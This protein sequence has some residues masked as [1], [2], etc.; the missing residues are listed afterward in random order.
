M[1]RHCLR[2]LA[3]LV[4]TG[5]CLSP[6]FAQSFTANC[7]LPFAHPSPK[8]NF[9]RSCPNA[10]I[11][12]DSTGTTDDAAARAVEYERK[13][14]LCAL[15]LGPVVDLDFA[16]LYRLQ[17]QAD[18]K[19]ADGNFKIGHGMPSMPD[20]SV[21]KNMP[22]ADG[23]SIDEGQPVRLV[24]YVADVKKSGSDEGVNCHNT[25]ELKTD[26]HINLSPAKDDP[27]Q[28]VVV[29]ITPHH[30]P[31][32]WNHATTRNTLYMRGNVRV[33]NVVRVTGQ[34]FFDSRH[35]V[36]MVD[37]G[38]NDGNPAR[39][40]LWEIHPVYAI[41]ICKLPGRKKPSLTNC[42]IDDDS[43][44]TPFPE[45]IAKAAHKKPVKKHQK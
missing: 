38:V 36:K 39:E 8:S 22:L 37:T 40:S 44:W 27:Y 10:G 21:L 35:G 31:A 34:L 18:Q 23:R 30:R 11:T 7:A 29:E 4:V 15:T 12:D 6:V 13:N 24:G 1:R 25:T 20:R 19:S 16:D 17:D 9:D 41:D 45:V 14:D 33:V 43:L 2:Y 3:T 42:P 5:A 32:N 28:G 26:I